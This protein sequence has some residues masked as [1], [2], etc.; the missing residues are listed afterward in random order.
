MGDKAVEGEYIKA[1]GQSGGPQE[2][3][4]DL[5]LSITLATVVYALLAAG[6]F[7][8]ITWLIAIVIVY[9]KIDSVR[10]TWLETH[11]RWQMRTFWFG[12]LW[13]LVGIVLLFILIGHAVLLAVS[14]W[15]IYRIVKGWL[16]LYE[17]KPVYPYGAETA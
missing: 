15:V 10:G 5:N 17:R 14:V 13:C 3:N 9:V 2:P 4:N 16:N 6:F 12:I 8:G 11:F 1:D 7:T